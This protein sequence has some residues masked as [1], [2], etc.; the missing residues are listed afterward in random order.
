MITPMTAALV[1]TGRRLAL[2]AL[3]LLLAGCAA[4]TPDHAP[5][6]EVVGVEPLPGESLELRMAVKLRIVNPSKA[7][8][9][10][11]GIYLEMDVRGK[12][13]ATGV[14]DAQGSVPRFGEVVLTVPITVTAMAIWQQAIVISE[15]NVASASYRLHGKLSGP[16]FRSHR[17]ESE[18]EFEFPLVMPGRGGGPWQ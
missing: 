17:F 1:R 8:I 15:G 12:H 13:F 2:A 3:P 10:Y 7:A 16:I 6:V 14:S 11:D 5:K 9:D 18:G 4:L